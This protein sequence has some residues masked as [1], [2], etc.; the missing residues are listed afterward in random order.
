MQMQTFF[1]SGD[2]RING[3]GDPDWG[4]H[5]VGAGAIKGLDAETLLD[6]LEEQF[7]LPASPIQLGKGQ[8]RPGEVVGEEDEGL[9]GDGIAIA[10]CGATGR[11]NRVGPSGR[12]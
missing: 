4:A 9:A 12:S 6:P 3:D 8:R 10:R 11:D 2:E 7:D 5:G 1:Q